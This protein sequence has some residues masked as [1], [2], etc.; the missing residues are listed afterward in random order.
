MRQTIF[1]DMDGTLLC[2]GESAFEKEYL[3]RMVLFFE[4]RFP[5]QG[6]AIVKA[7]GYSAAAMRQPHAGCS[8]EMVFWQAFEHVS[9]FKRSDLEPL[10]LQY[11]GTDYAHIGDDYVPDADMRR[12]VQLLAQKGYRL[13]VATNPLVPQIANRE[14]VRWAGLA[15]VD[16]LEITSFEH[17]S[18][19]KPNVQFYQEICDRLSLDPQQCTMIGNSVQDDGVARQIGLEF[20]LLLGENPEGEPSYDGPQGTRRQLLELVEQLPAVTNC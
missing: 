2:M 4:Q 5:G 8:N 13:V 10:F 16:W 11:Y 18:S 3:R 17:Y 7:V 20:Y 12:A 6:K 14:R 1:F 15:D 9:G 19:C